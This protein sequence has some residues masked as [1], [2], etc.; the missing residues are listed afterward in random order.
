MAPLLRVSGMDGSWRSVLLDL[1]VRPRISGHDS[2]SES[3]FFRAPAGAST[4][5]IIGKSDYRLVG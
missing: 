3:W 4:T 1:E 5:Q 2:E